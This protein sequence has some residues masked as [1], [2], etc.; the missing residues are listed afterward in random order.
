MKTILR[1][2]WLKYEEFDWRLLTIEQRREFFTQRPTDDN[3]LTYWDH[4]KGKRPA[5]Q[6][7]SRGIQIT[8]Q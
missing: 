7:R 5:F 1:R 3:L 4:L 8:A 6:V 2:L